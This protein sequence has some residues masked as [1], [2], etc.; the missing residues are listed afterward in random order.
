[1]KDVKLRNYR[2]PKYDEPLIM[3]VGSPDAGASWFPP[4]GAKIDAA[5]PSLE[6]LLSPRARRQVPPAIPEID[7]YHVLM[8]F[9]RLSQMTLG[10]ETG[11]DIGEGTV[12]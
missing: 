2:A 8:H 12:P 5:V 4:A 3:E 1:M 10:M 6:E 11:I 7:Q 9:L